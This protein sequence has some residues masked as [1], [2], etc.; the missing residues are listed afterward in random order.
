MS[1][2]QRLA[3]NWSPIAIFVT[4]SLHLVSIGDCLLP[5]ET[6]DLNGHRLIGTW[7]QV[8]KVRADTFPDEVAGLTGNGLRTFPSTGETSANAMTVSVSPEAHRE[9]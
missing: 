1:I 3:K 6:I 7:S 4:E 5:C 9:G 8:I 2:M